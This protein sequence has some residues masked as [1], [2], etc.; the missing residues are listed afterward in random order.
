MLSRTKPRDDRD[1]TCAVSNPSLLIPAYQGTYPLGRE[2]AGVFHQA[3]R[4]PCCA[5][6]RFDDPP[7]E[8][9]DHFYSIEYPAVSES[10]YN[11]EG[12][13][14]P[15]KTQE[16]SSRVIALMQSFGFG[17]GSHVHE[18]GCA[19]GGTVQAVKEQGY[20]VSGT[21]LNKT[22]VQ[23]GRARGN[24]DIHAESAIDFLKQ[25]RQPCQVIYSYHAL[26]HFTDPFSFLRELRALMDPDGLVISF[27]P[28]SAALFPIVYGHS[29]YV[30][31]GYPEHVHLFSPGSA[32]ALAETT[33]FELLFLNTAPVNI[34]QEG[35]TS[36]AVHR[37]S[38]AARYLRNEPIN[39]YGEELIVVMTPVGSRLTEVFSRLHLDAEEYSRIQRERERFLMDQLSTFCLN[40]WA[41]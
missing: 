16:R 12:D 30:W 21:E 25:Q 38:V 33:G 1:A 2:Y 5:Y 3:K 20:N 40:P 39:R 26:E 7:D 35:P 34:G 18:F 6:L 4:C 17:L 11:V 10:W 22:A 37:D 9:L 31:F 28:N 19:F 36:R 32:K 8:V 13:Y 23:Q 24:L 41:E 27:L 29:H 15:A 14:N